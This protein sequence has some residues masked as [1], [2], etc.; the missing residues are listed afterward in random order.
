VLAQ[1]FKNLCTQGAI[2]GCIGVLDGWLLKIEIPPKCKVGN[3]CSFSSSHYQCYGLNVQG[4]CDH[5][6]QFLYISILGPG[7]MCDNIAYKQKVNGA[8]LHNLIESLP[9][10]YYMVADA[11]Y[12]PNWMFSFSY[13]GSGSF[14][15]TI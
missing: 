6:C 14:Y 3:V 9:A 5:H 15:S 8:L 4:V 2:D 13:W 11:A 7:V 1:G 10:G 12:T